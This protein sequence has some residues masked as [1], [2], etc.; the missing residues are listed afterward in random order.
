[1]HKEM[2]FLL[3]IL[4]Q[5]HIPIWLCIIKKRPEKNVLD[6]RFKNEY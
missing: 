6:S 4:F 2:H 3:N 5:L 1:M